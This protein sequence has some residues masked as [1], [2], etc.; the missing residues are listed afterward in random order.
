MMSTIPPAPIPPPEFVFWLSASLLT[1]VVG[2]AGPP[3]GVGAGAVVTGFSQMQVLRM[4]ARSIRPLNTSI[5]TDEGA[6]VIAGATTAAAKVS[7]H[8]RVPV[9][10]V[11][12]QPERQVSQFAADPPVVTSW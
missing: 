5:P 1:G 8:T 11:V 3:E 9:G 4:P 2:G 7:G 12:V 10:E 6:V